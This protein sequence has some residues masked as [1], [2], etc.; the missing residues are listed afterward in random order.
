MMCFRKF[1]VAKKVMNKTGGWIIR[2]F[3]RK[4][5]CITV[6]KKFIGESSSVSSISGIEKS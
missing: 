6:P 5:F 2:I 4:F 3:S 1:L